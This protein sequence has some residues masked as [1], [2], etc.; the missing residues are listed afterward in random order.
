MLN[1]NPFEVIEG[2]YKEHYSYLRN[3]LI[4]KDI[5]GSSKNS[6]SYTYKMLVSEGC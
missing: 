3:L 5:N 2:L 4:C 1:Q 6:T